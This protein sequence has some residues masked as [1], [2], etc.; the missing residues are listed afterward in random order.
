MKQRIL[1]TG[2]NGT[3]GHKLVPLLQD[4]G[5]TVRISSRSPRPAGSDADI[6]WAQASLEAQTGWPAAVQDVD[7]IVHL[8]SSP[9]K[10]GVDVSGTSHLLSAAK[11]AGVQHFVFISIVGVDKR[12]WFFYTAKHDCEQLISGSSIPFSILRATQFHD[13]AHMLLNDIFLRSSIGFL[14]K[15]WRIQPIDSG[16][17][18]AILFDA[19]QQGPSGYMPDAGGP[20]ILT[21]KEMA[22]IWMA[23]KGPRKVVALPFPFLMGKAFGTGHNLAPDNRVGQMTWAEWVTLNLAAPQEVSV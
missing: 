13:F 14:P 22:D 8:A 5:Y 1:I 6:E 9:F 16:E 3:L 2:G 12:D 15:G 7:T 21:V 18:A 10:R 11:Q 19:V 17:V 20:E 4:A 23:A